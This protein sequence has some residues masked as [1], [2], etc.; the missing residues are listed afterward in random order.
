MADQPTPAIALDSV[1]FIRGGRTI[2]DDVSLNVGAGEQWA[3][4]GPNGA[5]K[6]SL[7]GICSATTFPSRGSASILG[8]VMGRVDLRELRRSIGLVEPRHPTQSDLPVLSL[9]LTGVTGTTEWVPHW[10]PADDE[11]ERAE[12]WLAA[13]GLPSGGLRWRTMSQGERGRALIAR[14]LMAEPPLLLL[15]EPSTGLDLVGREVM[16][17]TIDDLPLS[18]PGITTIVV[19]HYFEELP[20]GTTHAALLSGGRLVAAGPVEEVLTD[21]PVSACFD[22]PI[23]VTRTPDGRWHAAAS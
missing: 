18:A 11:I 9:V 16:L 20:R 19:T 6:S 8:S 21:G 17:R 5:G 23:T 12:K 13:V 3:L 2:L 1:S 15:D 22:H 4:L 14:A 7:M 10:K